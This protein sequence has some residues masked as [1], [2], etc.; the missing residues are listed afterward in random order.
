MLDV[1]DTEAM[2]AYLE[3]YEYTSIRHVTATFLWH[4]LLSPA[5]P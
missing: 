2:L 4:T 1:D 3:W 5:P